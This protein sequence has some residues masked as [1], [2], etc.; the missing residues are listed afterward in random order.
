M[1]DS[2]PKGI[3]QVNITL[4]P[5]NTIQ[6]L[7]RAAPVCMVQDKLWQGKGISNPSYRSSRSVE[8]VELSA[9]GCELHEE[10]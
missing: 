2:L 9:E 8:V 1:P 7:L 6:Y 10:E 4:A 3:S 5:V